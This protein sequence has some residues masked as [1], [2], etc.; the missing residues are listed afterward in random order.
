MM[1]IISDNSLIEMEEIIDQ[2]WYMS[3]FRSLFS[4]MIFIDNARQMFF[5]LKRHLK[6]KK[7]RPLRAKFKRRQ[8]MKMIL[9]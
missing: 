4:H 3:L 1:K 5:V 7:K 9:S 8:F 2:F 6:W